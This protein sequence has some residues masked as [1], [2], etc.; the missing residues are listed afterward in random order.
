MRISAPLE[1]G[2]DRRNVWC[3][4]TEITNNG[5]G[6]YKF[7]DLLPEALGF[8]SKIYVIDVPGQVFYFDNNTNKLYNYTITDE[9][10]TIS[11]KTASGI[12]DVNNTSVVVNYDGSFINAYAHV[13][14]NNQTIL[15]DMEVAMGSVTFHL[16]K[17]P[18]NSVNCI[19]IYS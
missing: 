1:I 16:I 2:T 13:T 11:V 17:E 7:V 12:I 15:C 10:K 6:T 18:T 4:S 3:L 9:S 19:V 8:G 14:T 5:D